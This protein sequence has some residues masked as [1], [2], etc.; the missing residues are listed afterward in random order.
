MIPI[1]DTRHD[2]AWAKA[3]PQHYEKALTLGAA[4]PYTDEPDHAM[5]LRRQLEARAA[6]DTW[7]R[8][9][10]IACPTLIAAGKFDGIAL[11]A[12]QEKMAARIPDATLRFFEG[13]HIFMLQ[14]R[15]A[16]PA[17]IEFLQRA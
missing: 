8:L 17:M 12:T 2:A 16:L 13:G 11:P 3:N 5:G 1:S 4:D 15:A 9:P 14:D 6:H 7:D 10:R